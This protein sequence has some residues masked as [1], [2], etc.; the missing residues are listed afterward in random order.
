MGLTEG[1]SLSG[2]PSVALVICL[3]AG[4]ERDL[5]SLLGPREM[6]VLL[7]SGLFQ[8]RE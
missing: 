1:F 4:Q 5:C 8:G 3:S 6:M 2:T 7:T